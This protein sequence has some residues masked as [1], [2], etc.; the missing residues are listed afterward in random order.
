[1][2]VLT[3]NCFMCVNKR[4]GFKGYTQSYVILIAVK[5]LNVR[6]GMNQAGVDNSSPSK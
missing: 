1:M 4:D 5:L 2:S 6:Q 3:C